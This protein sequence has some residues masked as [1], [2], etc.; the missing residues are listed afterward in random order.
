MRIEPPHLIP[1]RSHRAESRSSQ[2]SA[3]A[4]TSTCKSPFCPS[5]TTSC[6][7]LVQRSKLWTSQSQ[8]A[9]QVA[10]LGR[11]QTTFSSENARGMRHCLNR[12][13]LNRHCLNRHCLNRHCLN[14][15]CLQMQHQD[16][17]GKWLVVGTITGGRGDLI[18]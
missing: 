4:K 13:C 14:R 7:L 1:S 6:K 3:H 9:V 10:S 12:H 17:V 5:E 15:H 11:C 2:R 16:Q 8:T 18:V